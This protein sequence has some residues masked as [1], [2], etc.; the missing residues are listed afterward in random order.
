MVRN[1]WSTDEDSVRID[2]RQAGNQSPTIFVF[3][4]KRAEIA[5]YLVESK[6]STATLAKRVHRLL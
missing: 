5:N 2:A 1:E 6:A 4:P 3:I